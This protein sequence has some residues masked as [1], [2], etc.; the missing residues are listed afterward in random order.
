M[1]LK[2]LKSAVDTFAGDFAEFKTANETRLKELEEKGVESADSTAKVQEIAE[3]LAKQSEEVDKVKAALAR[4]PAVATDAKGTPECLT[5]YKAALNAH[6][7]G[8]AD[9]DVVKVAAK[10]VRDA[11]KEDPKLFA[12]YK[13]NYV[14]SDPDGGFG[15]GT[16][17]GGMLDP[18]ITEFS[19]MRQFATVRTGMKPEL[20]YVVNKKGSGSVVKASELQ[21]YAATATANLGEQIIPA[22]NH[23]ALPGVSENMLED[24]DFDVLGWQ[25]VEVGETFASYDDNQFF[26]GDGAG[27]A[28]GILTRTTIANTSGDTYGKVKLYAS[29]GATSFVAENLIECSGGLKRPYYSGRCNWFVKRQDFFSKIATLKNGDNDFRLVLPDFTNG[30]S[31]RLVGFDVAFAPDMPTAGTENNLALAFGNFGRA[32]TIYDRTGISVKRFEE[33]ESPIVQF[34]YRRRNGGDVTNFEA[35]NLVKMTAS[36]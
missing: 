17:E 32:Y 36:V 18:I 7:C 14:G 9:E 23:Y 28:K 10:A 6:L 12:D 33:V 8:H 22:H 34:R 30:V 11:I 26:N 21:A 19:N 15:V 16:E 4:M 20:R 13:T 5:E 1:E 27:E 2:E 35:Y 29:G 31:F 24:A 25:N 3:S